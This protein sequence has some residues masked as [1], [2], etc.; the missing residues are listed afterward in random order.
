MRIGLISSGYP[1][2]LDGIGD[3]TW[4]LAKTLA[5]RPE[6][7][8]PVTVF[9]RVGAEHTKSEGVKVIPF[10]DPLRPKSFRDLLGTPAVNDLDWLV[11]QYN[12]FGFGR[13]GYCPWVPETLALLKRTQKRPRIAVMFHE[14]VVPRWPWKFALMYCWQQP[15]F[16]SICRTAD[17]AFVSTERWTPQVKCASPNLP[18]HHL[19]VGSNVPLS[20]ISHADARQ[21][22]GLEKDAL[23]FGVFGSA[24]I[25]RRIDWIG[26]TV[27]AAAR[28]YNGRRTVL[29]YVGAQGEILRRSC[30]HADFIDAGRLPAEDISRYLRTMDAV[31]SP[32][33]DGISTRRTSVISV[34]H[35]GV[36][37]ATSRSPWTDDLFVIDTPAGLLLSRAASAEDFARETLDWMRLLP[38]RGIPD[39]EITAFYDRHFQWPTISA[40]MIRHL[41]T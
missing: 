27:T 26:A 14:T 6:I 30:P 20:E 5:E 22:C 21:R 34:L 29:L 32:F 16:R 9:T 11:L 15:I 25:S 18:V 36:P 31:I 10:F 38:D 35:H 17:V 19:P 28:E 13:W 23:V 40:T 3:Y 37:V 12:P 1:P 7:T 41:T 39:A 24:H 8:K 4:W 2:D 33:L